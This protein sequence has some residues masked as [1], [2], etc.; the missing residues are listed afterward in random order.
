MAVPDVRHWEIFVALGKKGAA[1]GSLVS[2]AFLAA[3]AL[4]MGAELVTDDGGLGRWPG[5]RWR[6][7]IDE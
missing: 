7:P 6:R 5:S 1:R 3:I 2:D 4:E